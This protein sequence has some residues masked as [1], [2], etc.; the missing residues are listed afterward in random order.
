MLTGPADA[1][2]GTRSAEALRELLV[3]DVGGHRCGLPVEAIVEIHPAVQLTPLPDAPEVVVGLVNRRRTV[4]PV[5]DLRRR[6]GLPSRPLHPDDRLVV[7]QKRGGEI[8]LLV[9]AAVDVLAISAA[10]VDDAITTGVQAAYSGGVAVLPDGLL[11]SGPRAR[12]CRPVGQPSRRG[13][14]WRTGGARSGGGAS[15]RCDPGPAG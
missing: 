4:L 9:D 1:D 6:L 13:P 11:V 3:T 2:E 14:Q 7:V 15:P 10:D 12:G 5:L 8:A